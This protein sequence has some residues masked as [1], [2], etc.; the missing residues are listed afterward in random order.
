MLV[1]TARG[2][3]LLLILAVL[4]SACNNPTSPAGR[5]F[6]LAGVIRDSSSSR[7]VPDATVQ[8]TTGSLAG[9]ATTSDALGQFHFTELASSDE[10]TTLTVLKFGYSP[11]IVRVD[12]TDV[13]ITLSSSRLPIEGDYTMIFTAADE[14]DMLPSALRRR[15]YAATIVLSRTFSSSMDGNFDIELS[16]ADFFPELRTIAMSIRSG[17]SNVFI[18]SSEAERKWGDDIPVYERVRA[19]EHLSLHGRA[20]GSVSVTDTALTTTFDGVIAYCP[21]STAPRFAAGYPPTC[22]M[23]PIECRS[24]RHQLTASRR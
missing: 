18:S 12:R 7:P 6:F 2:R 24:G 19:G 17:R 23:P 16:G 4:G 14:C 9:R 20:E 5:T 8:V 22:A 15:A 11:A 1:V 3:V 10:P 13:V 21:T